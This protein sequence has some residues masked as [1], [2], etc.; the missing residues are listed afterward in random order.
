MKFEEKPHKGLRGLTT[1]WREDLVAA[2]S[3]SLVALPLVLGIAIASGVPPIA[4]LISAII[5]GIVTTLFRGSCY[6]KIKNKVFHFIPA[7][8]W[9]LV[10]SIPLVFLFDF[11]DPR[12]ISLPG[13]SYDV[14]PQYLTSLPDN[15]LDGFMFPD[16]SMIG[17]GA[18]WLAVISVCLI[19]SLETLISAKAVE[20]LDP[21]KR[22]TRIIKIKSPPYPDYV[23]KDE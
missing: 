11:F 4:G 10:L 18:F 20:K 2:F 23:K 15:L 19:S 13:K 16:F 5:G 17:T 6:P 21:Y 7:P 14:G 22:K 1:H 8:M 9:I 3:V 12:K